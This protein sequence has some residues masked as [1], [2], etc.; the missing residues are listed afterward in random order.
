MKKILVIVFTL[1][2]ISTYSQIF[3]TDD[4]LDNYRLSQSEFQPI[5]ANDSN[6]FRN[7]NYVDLSTGICCLFVFASVYDRSKQTNKKERK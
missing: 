4:D 3:I 1:L 5:C 2:T 6:Y 7:N